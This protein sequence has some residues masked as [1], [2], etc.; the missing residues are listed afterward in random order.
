MKAIKIQTLDSGWSLYQVTVSNIKDK[1]KY[2]IEG[3]ENPVLSIENDEIV[4]YEVS[5]SEEHA[6]KQL[7]AKWNILRTEIFEQVK[8]TIDSANKE[9]ADQLWNKYNKN[10]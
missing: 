4:F 10:H 7:Q 6:I 2:Y 5:N 8:S 9:F 3:D 1:E